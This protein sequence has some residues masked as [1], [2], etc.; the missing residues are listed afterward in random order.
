MN[1]FARTVLSSPTSTAGGQI[2]FGDETAALPRTE[3]HVPSAR[4]MELQTHG[5]RKYPTSVLIRSSAGLGWSAI[6]AELRSHPASETPV[7]VP[8]TVELSLTVAGNDDGLVIRTRAGQRQET[9]PSTGTIWL[10]PVGVGDVVTIK[11][12]IPRTLHLYL[13]TTQ[14]QKL[15]DEFNIAG[16]PARS[17]RYVAGVQDEVIHQIGLSIISAMT[18]E[19]AAGRMFAET[20]SATLAARLLQTYCDSGTSKSCEPAHRL[21]QA[22]LRRVLDY[23]STNIDKEITLAQLAAVAALSVF[24]FARTFTRTMGVSP[25]RYVSRMRLENAMAELAAGKLSLAEVAFNAGFS[26]QASFTRAFN[27]VSG[28]TPG[29]YRALRR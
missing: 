5:A 27:R 11:A 26:S 23:I 15:A 6:S 7:I 1:Y 4:H 14:F 12:P 28:L 16:A 10:S 17:I 19:A 20:A 9:T 21:D 13:P 3:S 25:H 8:Q 2:D 18:N 29:E 22:R 24:H